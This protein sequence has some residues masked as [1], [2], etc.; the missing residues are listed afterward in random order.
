MAEQEMT[1]QQVAE[2][3]TPVTAQPQVDIDALLSKAREQEKAKLYPEIEKL[4]GEVKA[5]SD[6]LNAEIIK[7]ANLEDAVAEKEKEITRL[8]GL[9]E[10]AKQ[11]GKSLGEAELT[12]LAQ[13]RDTYKAEAEKVKAEF[14]A[15][16]NQQEVEAYKASKISDI[17]ED[18]RDLVVGSTKEEIDKNYTKAKALQNKVKEKYQKVD[19]PSPSMA[20]FFTDKSKNVLESVRDYDD[21]AYEKIRASIFGDAGSRKF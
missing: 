16:K 10:K 5:K 3:S 14:E 19:L 20:G 18:F 15:Y 1:E 7:S 9:I 4:K 11:E 21:S 17:D 6:K 12:A 13:E 2:P 8:N